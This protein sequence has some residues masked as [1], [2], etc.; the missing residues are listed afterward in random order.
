MIRIYLDVCCFNRPFD[1]QSQDRIRLE[2]EAVILILNHVENGDWI[3]VGS[4][5]IDYEIEQ[6]PNLDRQDKVKFLVKSIKEKVN[7]GK[8]EIVRGQELEKMGFKAI[9]SLH[10]ACAEKAKVNIFLTTDDKLLK[11]GLKNKDN[12]FVKI[13]DPLTWLTEVI[14]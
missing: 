8:K 2:A 13:K 9:D 7:F 1:D 12:L 4:D 10:I 14:I 3:L 11:Q 5:I 6:T